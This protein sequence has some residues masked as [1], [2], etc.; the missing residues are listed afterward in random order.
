[1]LKKLSSFVI[2]SGLLLVGCSN[3]DG[4]I[5]ALNEEI[6]QLEKVIAEQNSK[7]EKLENFTYLDAF[8]DE[9]LKHYDLFM[10]EYDSTYL[11][12]FSPEKIVLLY[13]HSLFMSDMEAVYAITYD[14]G[15]LPAFDDFTNQFYTSDYYLSTPDSLL[16]FKHYNSIQI[17]D[18]NRTEESLAV[19]IDTHYGTN[20]VVEIFGLRKEN[21]QWKIELL[22][23]L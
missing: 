8:T 3:N 11:V 1:M 19:E 2:L 10:E 18:E 6:T 14:G 16:T 7:I 22:H 4:E 23:L 9:E 20:Q 13:L 12:D 5:E 15:Q 21:N 17:R